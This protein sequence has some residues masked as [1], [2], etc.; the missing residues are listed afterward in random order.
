[1]GSCDTQSREVSEQAKHWVWKLPAI[2]S[3]VGF[4]G[5]VPSWRLGTMKWRSHKQR[6]V[7]TVSLSPLPEGPVQ[8]APYC[9]HAKIAAFTGTVPLFTHTNLKPTLTQGQ[10]WQPHSASSYLYPCFLWKTKAMHFL[11]ELT[12]LPPI[13]EYVQLADDLRAR[14]M[15]LELP[16]A[17]S[18]RSTAFICKRPWEQAYLMSF[19][20]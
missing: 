2:S 3:C 5:F 11:K 18:L 9:C 4:L 10:T 16:W 15:D 19:Y 20:R 14:S 17:S 6:G 7:G 13:C 12:L 8:P 1:M